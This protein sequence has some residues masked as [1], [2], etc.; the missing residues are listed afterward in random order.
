MSDL[1]SMEQTEADQ[2]TFKSPEGDSG[3]SSE[4]FQLL[5]E[6][7]QEYAIF[8]LDPQGRVSSWNRGAE[9][10]KGYKSFEIIGK[11]FSQFYL[12]AERESG[13]PD[14]ELKIAIATGKF[15]EAG[16]R[17]RKDGTIFWANVVIT[18]VYKN[19]VLLGFAKVTR[20]LTELK[21]AEDALKNSYA[22]LE[23]R[24]EQ[25]TRE[26]SWAKLSAENA[27]RER[28]LFFSVASHELKTPL[29]SL[30]LQSQL[31]KRSVAKGD[32]S[33]FAPEKLNE[34]CA[35]DE[36]QVERLSLLVDNMFDVAKITSGRFQIQIDE[37]HLNELIQQ[38]LKRM[39]PLLSENKID[40]EFQA[41]DEVRGRCD[42]LR[43]EQ[44]L[45]NLLSN[46]CKFARGKPV[47]ITLEK[48]DKFITMIVE[49]Q[50]PGLPP[51]HIKTLFNPFTRMREGVRMSGLGL[52]LYISKQ[53]VEAHGGQ[54]RIENKPGI[55]A[56]FIVELPIDM[57]LEDDPSWL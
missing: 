22:E 46:V 37:C 4:I 55:G 23:A 3:N 35:D 20:D 12:P 30:K 32:F 14:E 21:K 40:W 33:D 44:V 51:H 11:H 7:V 45:T 17:V 16:W 29:A 34:L 26:L 36:R 48:T 27:V 43:I 8:M 13:K 39:S 6:S 52:G 57:V 31:R 56:K 15:E 49:D 24:V 50:G 10:H 1:Y 9:R 28:D 25:R 18:P 47:T 19:D 38:T 2:K 41:S 54:I 53:I 42:R 5:V